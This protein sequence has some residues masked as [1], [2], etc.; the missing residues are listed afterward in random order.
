MLGWNAGP[1]AWRPASA[2]VGKGFPAEWTV[3]GG[4]A[5]AR[6][7]VALPVQ[8]LPVSG[9]MG[10]PQRVGRTGFVP[11]PLQADA[12]PPALAPPNSVSS[13]HAADG[14]A[15]RVSRALP[16][17]WDKQGHGPCALLGVQGQPMQKEHFCVPARVRRAVPTV[18]LGIQSRVPWGHQR[19][20][21]VGWH[22]HRALK[23]GTKEGKMG[24][25]L[26]AGGLE[27]VRT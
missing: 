5:A 13:P 24:T 21:R 11:S 20:H 12:P 16:G 8:A 18:C 19:S 6:E 27:R 23:M 1:P 4:C 22:L 14:S 25:S 26:P 2:A 3:V 10:G 17:G 15:S 7:L 9:G